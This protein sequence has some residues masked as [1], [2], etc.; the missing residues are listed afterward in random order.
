MS[1]TIFRILKQRKYFFTFLIFSLA[2]GVF[3]PLIQV[4]QQGANNFFFW[5]SLLKPVDWFFYVVF[6]LLFGSSFS[7]F[8]WRNDS[9]V[10]SVNQKLHT[11]IWGGLG[12]F[13]S[14]TMPLC[15]GCLS[16]LIL[17]FPV[18]ILGI[19]FQYRFWVMLLSV[20]LMLVSLVILG[21]F[22]KT[23]INNQQK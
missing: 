18:G 11:G 10:C 21:A 9:K 6:C 12:T 19:L 23:V 8:S 14:V 13:L 17:L 20:G 15:P 7:L 4:A 22:E 16:F 1:F 3:Y 5:F 2:M